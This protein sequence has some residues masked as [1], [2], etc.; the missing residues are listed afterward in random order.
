MD[1]RTER[2]H[3]PRYFVPAHTHVPASLCVDGEHYLGKIVNLSERG[4]LLVTERSMPAT[5]RADWEVQYCGHTFR[6]SGR[7]DRRDETHIGIEPE[8]ALE[9]KPLIKLINVSGRPLGAIQRHDSQAVVKG[10]LDFETARHLLRQV[11]A[12]DSEI[13]LSGCADLDSAGL[14]VLLIAQKEGVRLRG[15]QGKV[16]QIV[17]IVGMCRQCPPDPDCPGQ[18]ANHSFRAAAAA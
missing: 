4:F 13:D 9:L 14:G 16:Q 5:G 6:G 1:K 10:F 2:R 15:C 12:G 8:N 11:R 3:S 7:L 18:K 17:S